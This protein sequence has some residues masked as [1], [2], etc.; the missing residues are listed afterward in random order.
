[1]AG[2]G[3]RRSCVPGAC[4]PFF[5]AP[6]QLAASA[7]LDRYQRAQLMGLL[8]RGLTGL[9]PP[10]RKASSRDAAVQVNPRRDSSV[11]CSLGRLTLQRRN[12]DP[13]GPPGGPEL[14]ST[15]SRAPRSGRFPRPVAVYSPV[16]SRR[17]PKLGEKDAGDAGQPG[18]SP[19]STPRSPDS[20]GAEGGDPEKRPE[21][22]GDVATP[23]RAPSSPE[24][25]ASPPP[26][27]D[28]HEAGK[29]EP[30]PQILEPGPRLRFQVSPSLSPA[31]VGRWCGC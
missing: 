23:G 4:A 11:Q 8:S 21:T 7:Y 22:A 24:Q 27:E 1:M 26:P 9:A 16:T 14:G 29:E 15:P 13:G 6:G 20:R 31:Q 17:V 30:E 3:G 28:E 10:P 12:R 5:Q 25:P 2:A 19:T 18:A